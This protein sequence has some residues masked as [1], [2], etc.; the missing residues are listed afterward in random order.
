MFSNLIFNYFQNEKNREISEKYI[1]AGLFLT[2][3]NLEKSKQIYEEIV[4]DKNKFYSFLALNKIIENDLEK[5]EK[6][7]LEFFENI[8]KIKVEENQKNLIKL[9][10]ALYLININRKEEGKILLKEIISEDTL[11]KET[12]QEILK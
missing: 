8:Q 10:K 5:N 6:K 12:A 7:I 1:K 4:L 3:N 9:K 11:W 2:S